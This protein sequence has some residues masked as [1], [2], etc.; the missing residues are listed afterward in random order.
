M[1]QCTQ[2]KPTPT[3]SPNKAWGLN[4]NQN[5]WVYDPELAPS[6]QIYFDYTPNAWV[7]DPKLAPSTWLCFDCTPKHLGL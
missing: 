7:Y 4:A 2:L 1:G 6:T 5:A 3:K